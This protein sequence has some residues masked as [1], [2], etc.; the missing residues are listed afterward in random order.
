MKTLS[1]PLA[2]LTC[3][4]ASSAA[5]HSEAGDSEAVLSTPAP[6]E[7]PALF[8]VCD[9]FDYA[10]WYSNQDNPILQKFAFTG[11][12]Q[13]DAAYYDAEGEDSFDDVLWRRVRG[14]FK[15]GLF[16]EFTLHSEAD[17]DL[18]DYDPAYN[19]LTDTYLGWSPSDAFELKIGKIGVGFTLDGATSSKKLIRLE[20]SL[21]A[22]NL[23]FT[24]EYFTGTAVS[25]GIGN[26]IYNFGAYSADR[27]DPEFGSFDAGYFGLASLGYDFADVFGV[28]KAIIR[29]DYVYNEEDENNATRSLS[30]V[31][32]L[33]SWI[34]QGDWG[35]GTDVGAGRG[36][37]SQ[38][39]LFSV[40]V[41]PFFRVNEKVQLVTSYTYITSDGDNG[42]RLDRY[43]SS[44]EGGR[45]DRAHEFYG[46]FNYYLCGH[47]LKWQTGI[48]YTSASDSANDGGAYDGWGVTTGIRISW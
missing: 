27:S 18:N 2:A 42:V 33:N 26:W 44:V 24:N 43:E 19:G 45:P 32:S 38:P 39:D 37:L 20:R 7:A 12:L 5:L 11:R 25:G 21:L 9:I 28:E 48:E 15:I 16:Q 23:W 10:T 22:N 31:G 36:Y 40:Q 41:M 4:L 46:G 29:A 34:E 17:F 13:A 3:I 8:S 30:Q 6:I 47:N 35:I 14:G 1:K